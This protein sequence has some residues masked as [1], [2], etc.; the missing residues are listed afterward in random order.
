MVVVSSVKLT[1][2]TPEQLSINSKLGI[3]GTLEQLTFNSSSI[4]VIIVGAVLSYTV[5]FCV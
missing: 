1:F 2:A 3:S 4:G 5:I